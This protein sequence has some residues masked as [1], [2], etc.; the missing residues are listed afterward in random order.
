MFALTVWIVD[1]ITTLKSLSAAELERQWGN[2]LYGEVDLRIGDYRWEALMVPETWGNPPQGHENLRYWIEAFLDAAL[3]MAKQGDY[4][5]FWQI[6]MVGIWY[7]FERHEQTVQIS[8]ADDTGI[9]INDGQFDM[10]RGLQDTFLHS[11]SDALRKRDGCMAEVSVTEFCNHVL[12]VSEEFLLDMCFINESL[13]GSKLF[14]NLERKTAELK[15]AM[16]K[17]I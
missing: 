7:V 4:A 12:S 10:T 16:G 13:K 17:A 5:A 9:T 11:S 2:S 1:D 8:V 6:D 15:Q 14:R 3:I